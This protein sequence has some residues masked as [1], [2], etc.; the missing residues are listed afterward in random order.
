MSNE[1]KM[2]LKEEVVTALKN[3]GFTFIINEDLVLFNHVIMDETIVLSNRTITIIPMVSNKDGLFKKLL[4][5][6]YFSI[7]EELKSGEEKHVVVPS[8]KGTSFD[9]DD[10]KSISAISKDVLS[11]FNI[12]DSDKTPKL[13]GVLINYLTELGLIIKIDNKNQLTEDGRALGK[14]K[15]YDNGEGIVWNTE[16]ILPFLINIDRNKLIKSN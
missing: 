7:I 12:N 14:Y 15:Q 2:K 4:G 10:Y 8:M 6:R 3:K 1:K 13:T 9:Y 5:T 11:H 16:K